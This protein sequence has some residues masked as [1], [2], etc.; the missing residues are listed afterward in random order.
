MDSRLR[1]DDA[2]QCHPRASGNPAFGG[3]KRGMTEL[4]AGGGPAGGAPALW[5]ERGDAGL[6]G[7]V[8]DVD[9]QVPSSC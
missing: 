9:V 6:A 3:P 8:R 2:L 1:G 7:A 5:W 4:S